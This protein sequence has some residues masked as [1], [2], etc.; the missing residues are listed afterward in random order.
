MANLKLTTFFFPLKALIEELHNNY[1]RLR[2]LLSQL[3]CESCMNHTS[4]YISSSLTSCLKTITN[5]SKQ[6]DTQTTGTA[7][8]KLSNSTV[9]N[10]V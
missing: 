5:A 6:F 7:D 10:A 8:R 3:V 9:H 1:L 4:L 2:L